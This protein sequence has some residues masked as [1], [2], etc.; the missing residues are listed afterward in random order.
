MTDLAGRLRAALAFTVAAAIVVVSPGLEA[1]RLFAQVIGRT[2][3]VER[4]SPA[5]GLPASS[6]ASTPAGFVLAPLIAA[7]S[8]GAP[9]AVAA[10]PAGRAAS[11][12]EMA[13]SLAPYLEAVAKPETS[14]S[15]S[16]AA[17]RGIEDVITGGRSAGAGDVSSA[18]GSESFGASALSAGGAADAAAEAPKT[19][20]PAAASAAVKTVDSEISYRVHRLL[21]KAVAALT[22]AVYSQPAAGPALTRTLIR[23][24]ASRSAVFSDY[25]DTL[26]SYNQVLPADMV[27]AVQAVKAAGKDFV[28]ISDR[29]DEPRKDSLTVFESLA[30]LPAETR[31]GMYVAANSG[32][33]VYR[34]DATGLVPARVFETP[35]LDAAAKAKIAA[36]S[37]AT[38]ARLKEIGAEIYVPVAEK[39]I[40]SES[41]TTYGYTIMLKVGSSNAVVRGAADIL[42]EELRRRGIAVEVNPRFA[43]D[44]S[45]PPYAT[46]STV[47]KQTA[48]AY[49]AK[50]LKLEARDVLFIGDSMYTP[51]EAKTASWLARFGARLSGRALPPTGNRTDANMAKAVPGALTFSVGTTGDPRAEN[52]WVLGG[53]GPSVTREVLM[54]V[55]SKPR[56]ALHSAGFGAIGGGRDFLSNPSA[57]YAE[58]RKKAVEIAAARGVQAAQVLFVQATASMPVRDG[59]HW[60]YQFSI[61]GKN[62]GRALIYAD[63]SRFLGGALEARTSVYENAPEQAGLALAL[64]PVPFLTAAKNLDPEQALDAARRAAPGL[65]AGVSVALDYRDE[66]A[67]GGGDL[68]YRFY[69]DNGGVV[70]VNARTSEAR[71]DAAPPSDRS[72]RATAAVVTIGLIAAAAGLL[73][74]TH[75]GAL[76]GG[77]LGLAALSGTILPVQPAKVG[78]DEI[79]QA[80]KSVIASKGGIWSRTEYSM[81][82]SNSIA[83]LT[84]RGATK[85]Q[86]ARFRKLCDDAPVINGRFNP[87]SGD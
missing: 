69:D 5:I 26:A 67:A 41:W 43:K 3:P 24:A 72:S 29:G 57:M 33:R 18:A 21:L 22:G 11:V 23:S 71:V 30:S 83:N 87:W 25:D 49:I 19:A 50:A 79:A 80:A 28:F 61:P 2:A 20:V 73:A 68:W 52:L 31:A 66:P 17:G 8:L 35:P 84:K 58:A 7:P 32:G 54:S 63:T 70:S 75:I 38:K 40:P 60:H 86:I 34:Y 12:P 64:E 44:P 77:A 6:P 81:G 1:P 45:N 46:F 42:Q 78:D 59:A 27:S 85:E 53:K 37:E 65:G 13:Q 62:G 9:S 55:A 47:T 36:A 56:T 10:A 48:A 15:G 74:L 14:A 39:A 4:I 16:A 51:H 76:L 82:Y